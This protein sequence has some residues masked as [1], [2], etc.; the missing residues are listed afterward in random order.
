[1][2]SVTHL[3][4]SILFGRSLQ[5]SQCTRYQVLLYAMYYYQVRNKLVVILITNHFNIK[6][7]NMFVNIFF[8]IETRIK[9]VIIYLILLFKRV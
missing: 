2:H 6:V 1:M 4:S 5:G 8:Q 7:I 9:I 3:C